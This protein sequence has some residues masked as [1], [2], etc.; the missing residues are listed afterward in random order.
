MPYS[1]S[2]YTSDSYGGSSSYGGVKEY[3]S[4]RTA[5]YEPPSYSSRRPTY[6]YSTDL[7]RTK[8][9]DFR[10]SSRYKDDLRD[11]DSQLNSLKLSSSSYKPS[12]TTSSGLSSSS[13]LIIFVD[14]LWDHHIPP[15]L[16]FLRRAFTTDT[17]VPV[18]VPVAAA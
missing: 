3:L 14:L 9:E 6:N 7:E 8:S 11:L 4:S 5:S 18:S 13:I 10:P 17:Q 1:S 16:L 2:R 12:Y 15:R